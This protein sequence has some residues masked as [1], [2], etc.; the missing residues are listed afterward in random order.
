MKNQKSF[1]KTVGWLAILSAIFGYANFVLNGIASGGNSDSLSDMSSFIQVG[2]TAGNI[3]KWSWLSDMLG[4]YL[5]LVPAIFLL[6]YWLKNRNPYWMGILTFCGLAYTLCGSIGAS[7]LAKT[8]PSL[9][10]AYANSEGVTKEMYDIVFTNNTEMVYGGIWGYLEFLFAGV[11]WI[12]I[13]FTMKS[14]R[15]AL[16]IVTIILG[17]FT[18]IATLGEYFALENI[19]LIGLMVYLLLAPIW[20]GWLGVSLLRGKDI[21]LSISK[22]E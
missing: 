15:K 16:G 1:I 6:H 10:S 22:P 9:I 3:L 14:E 12:G 8:W 21:K 13:G 18:L 4:Y 20:S 2:E 11:W 17:V 19:A 5:L 7:M